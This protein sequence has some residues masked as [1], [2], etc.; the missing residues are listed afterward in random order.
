MIEL[1]CEVWT[2]AKDCALCITT[3]G[4][5]TQNGNGIMGAGIAGETVRLYEGI[6]KKLGAYLKN[7]GHNVGLLHTDTSKNLDLLVFPTKHEVYYNSDIDLIKRSALQLVQ[8]CMTR[9]YKKIYIPQP[10]CGCGGLLWKNVKPVIESILID[11]K[12]IIVNK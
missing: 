8:Y 4:T 12:F 11:D 2:I 9:D 3:N 7:N 10:G 5:I 1:K 6:E